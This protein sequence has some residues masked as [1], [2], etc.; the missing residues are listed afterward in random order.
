MK[1]ICKTCNKE[2]EAKRSSA[3]FCSNKC[4][5]ACRRGEVSVSKV[6]VS[7]KKEVSVSV[8]GKDVKDMSRDELRMHIHSYRGGDWVDSPEHNELKRRL[9][10]WSLKKLEELNYWIPNW[11][12]NFGK[13][14]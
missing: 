6:S 9:K 7:P 3:K 4:K 8:G 14:V 1:A 10:T 11:K 2:F 13:N 12:R 5:L